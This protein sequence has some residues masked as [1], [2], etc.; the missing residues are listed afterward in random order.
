MNINRNKDTL[1]SK[2]NTWKVSF[3]FVFKQMS[4]VI[5]K[6]ADFYNWFRYFV[7]FC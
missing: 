2:I 3:V 7:L 6:T 1:D 4:M 5:Q